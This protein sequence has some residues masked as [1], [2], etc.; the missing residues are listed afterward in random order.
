MYTVYRGIVYIVHSVPCTV[1]TRT[2]SVGGFSTVYTVYR[3]IVY[4]VHSVPCTVYT[5][6]ASVGG[7]STVYTVYRGIVYIVHSVPC[8]VYSVHAYCICWGVLVQFTQCIVYSAF[9]T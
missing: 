2:A 3:G 4:I 9:C 5:R 6:T 1:Y 8:T 7:F